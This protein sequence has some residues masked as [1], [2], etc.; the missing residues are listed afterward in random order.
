MFRQ[1]TRAQR[2]ISQPVE[3][4]GIGFVTGADIRLRFVPAPPSTG[5]VF[6]RTDLPGQ[7]T[8]PAHVS[9]VTNTHRR[10]TLT[11]NNGEVS[12]VEH[13]LAALAGLRI[14]NC[15]VEL[16]GPEAP[17]MDGS[18]HEFTQALLSA[19]IERQSER[20]SIWRVTETIVLVEGESSVAL[21]PTPEDDLKVSYILDYGKHPSLGKQRFTMQV[22]PTTFANEI[23]PSRTF[24]LESEVEML[25]SMG[26]GKRSTAK[27]LLIY[28]EEGVIDNEVHWSN[29][30][31]RHKALDMLGDLSLLGVDLH[32]HLIGYRTGHPQN[33]ALAQELNKHLNASLGCKTQRAA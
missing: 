21:Y 20:R 10:T 3:V 5:I 22:S 6:Q 26:L 9:Q 18:A 24:I 28:G 8:I 12:L 17:G 11:A 25:R 30:P 4:Q 14:D 13:V 31:A 32:G 19:G 7:V 29:E 1:S 27:D 16:N 15:T 2:T 23:A 33:V